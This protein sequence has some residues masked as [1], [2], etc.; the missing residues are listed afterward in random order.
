MVT[1]CAHIRMHDADAFEDGVSA[2][3]GVSLVKRGEAKTLRDRRLCD[4]PVYGID[5]SYDNT[6]YIDR[7]TTLGERLL[8]ERIY[9][10][11]WV[12]TVDL[13]TGQV[14]EPSAAMTFDKFM[15][16]IKSWIDIARA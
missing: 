12:V 15:A 13:E 10:A 3:P 8:S 11:V 14:F 7:F 4:T 2:Y 9:Q 6:S 5:S 1:A 16:N